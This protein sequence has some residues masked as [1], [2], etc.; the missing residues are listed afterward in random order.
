[1][2]NKMNSSHGAVAATKA[3]P[4]T[5]L[6]SVVADAD[7]LLK[8]VA[9]S[10]AEE[11]AA[12]RTKIEGKLEE[13]R[14]A[15]SDSLDWMSF[16]DGGAQAR[17]DRYIGSRGGERRGRVAGRAAPGGASLSRPRPK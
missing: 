5:D 10:T 1:M 4:V 2:N 3:K 11:F 6:R 16:I 17:L 7:D 9:H 12:V 14:R 8:E 13:S 15:L